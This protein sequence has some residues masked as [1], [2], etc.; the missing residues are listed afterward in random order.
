MGPNLMTRLTVPLTLVSAMLLLTAGGA[1]WY[2]HRLQ[3]TYAAVMANEVASVQAAQELE[4]SV[5]EVQAQFDRYLI[6]RDRK[7]LDAV[8]RLKQRTEA[9][10]A[11]AERLAMTPPEKA[12]MARV[13]LGFDHF[14]REYEGFAGAAGG[15]ELHGRVAGLIDTVLDEEILDPTHE[16][17]RLNEGMASQTSRANEAQ[18]DR[19]AVGLVALGLCGAVGGLLAGWSL[20]AAVR[21]SLRQTEAALRDTAVRL[22][23]AEPAGSARDTWRQVSES[24]TAVLQRLEQ[25]ERDALRAEQLAW[26]GQMAAGIAHEVR[27]PLMAIK[28]IVQAAGDP[29]RRHRFG[30]RDLAV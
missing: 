20:A 6:T 8:P 12:L 1:A 30:P 21:R 3:A 15:A 13:R 24:V 7:H 11:E 16:Y 28:L 5:R 26:A 17:L 19:L 27:N 23:G 9:A 2:V 25:S 10:L 22:T 29:G 4:I 14:F 18:A